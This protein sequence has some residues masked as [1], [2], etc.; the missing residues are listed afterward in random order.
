LFINSVLSMSIII[1]I[2]LFSNQPM[3]GLV[4]LIKFI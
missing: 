4:I 1:P 2:I 3:E